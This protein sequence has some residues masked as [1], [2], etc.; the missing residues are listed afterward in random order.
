MISKRH[1]EHGAT[2]IESLIAVCLFAVTA[3]A[4]GNMLV[5]Q[6]RAQGSN[7]ARTQAIA[8]AAQELEDLR[9]MD[10]TLIATRSSTKTVGSKTYTVNTTVLE[11]QPAANMKTIATSVSWTEP[12][13]TQ[14]YALNA[15]YTA[16][17]R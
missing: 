13:G 3:S 16:I 1:N 6:V 9:A 5:Q 7:L 2:L 17:K 11:G 8:L 4:V 10:Y 15:I 12:S 14:T